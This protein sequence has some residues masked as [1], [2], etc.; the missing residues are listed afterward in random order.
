MVSLNPSLRTGPS[1]STKSSVKTPVP[2]W[3]LQDLTGTARTW[4]ARSW[5]SLDEPLES[6]VGMGR[7]GT[8]WVT[9]PG[10]AEPGTFPKIVSDYH[11]I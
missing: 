3:D 7:V 1:P 2:G 4:L 10:P 6:P 5:R 8:R 11:L 9:A